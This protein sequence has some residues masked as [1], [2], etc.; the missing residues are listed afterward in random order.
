MPGTS[1]LSSAHRCGR[2]RRPA[3][4]RTASSGRN[5][6]DLLHVAVGGCG[7]LLRT[8]P[9]L[10]R[11]QVGRV[12]VPPVVLAV[13]PL[14]LAVVLFSLVEQLRKGCDLRGPCPRRLPLA[15]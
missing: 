13:R 4:T 12:P 11:A 14:V 2:R 7:R 10:A 6:M 5:L 9:L 8:A 15:S 1:L 3:P